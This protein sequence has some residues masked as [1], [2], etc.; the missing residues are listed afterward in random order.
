MKKK[1]LATLLAGSMVFSLA[2]CGGS[3]DT[4]AASEP[5]DSSVEATAEPTAEPAPEPTAAPAVEKLPASIDFE[6]GKMDFL[7][8]Y[9][10]AG[11][12]DNSELS[13]VDKDGSK[14]LYVKNVDGKVS[15]VAFDL[16]ALLGAN[17]A[18]VAS[19]EMTITTEHE[20]GFS[21][22]SG[23]IISW[24]GADL[25]EYKDAWSVYM[26]T[27]NPNKAVSKM[28]EGEEFAADANNIIIVN[29]DTDNGPSEGHGVGSFYIDDVRFLDKDGNLITADTS[30]AFVGPESFA[31]TGVDMSNLCAVTGAVEIEGFQKSGAGWAQDGVELTAEQWDA[32]GPGSVIEISYKSETGNMWVVFPW[33]AAWTR[34]GDGNNGKAYL[35][36]SGNVCQIT[37]EQVVEFLGEDKS[38]WGTML[39]CESDS[40]WEVYSVKVG[41]AAPVYTMS[42]AVEIEGF[43]KKA[44]GW[45]QDGVELTPEQW[46]AFGPGTTIELSYTSETGNMWVVFPWGAAWTRIGDGNNGKSTCMDGKCYITYEQVVEFLCED[47]STWGTMLQAESD[48][49]WEV[50]SVKVGTVAEMKMVNNLVTVDGFQK[51]GAG[52]AQDGIELTPEQW[53]LVGPGSVISFSFTSETGKLW[54]VFPWGA[55]WTRIG[56]GNNG[57]ALVKD[58]VCQIPYELIVEYLGEDKSTWGTM[59]QAESDGAWEVYNVTIGQSPVTETE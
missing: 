58:G 44:A 1:L 49:A 40:A 4:P 23:N 24:A 35:N 51:K 53:D 2:A 18:N 38:T 32:F 57:N 37:Y 56:D 47:K 52:W 8:L 11:N 21:A 5:V 59:L 26:D 48:S 10:Q 27:K 45:A 7:S 42:N 30:V 9:M 14:Q 17:I 3:A 25:V 33:G 12:A 29:M 34:I 41:Q 31:P 55:A 20:G 36:N 46:D 16:A 28:D 19:I 50:Y 13:I 54:A 43:Q 22:S 39:Q 6:D 15:Y